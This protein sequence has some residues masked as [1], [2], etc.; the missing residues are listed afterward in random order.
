M[1]AMEWSDKGI[2]LSARPHG[3]T[4]SVAM[5]FTEFH[6]RHAGLVRGG[7]GQ[8]ARGLYQA[9]NVV[10]VVWRARLEE[11]LGNFRCELVHAAA[12]G[13]LHDALRLS[14]L[15]AACAVLQ[16]ALPER[17]PYATLYAR[18]VRLGE[19]IET[20]ENWGVSYARFELELLAEL[21]FGLDLSAC[22]VTGKAEDLL[23]VSPRS[24]RAVSAAA[25]AQWREKLLPLPEF[26][27]QPDGTPPE[28]AALS[29]ALQLTGW[30]LATHIF[31][32]STV[33]PARERFLQRLQKAV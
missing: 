31:A 1:R 30:F 11:H 25:G 17:H 15:S 29:D 18:F 14:A 6:G 13:L 8:R 16:A 12:A 19:E 2:V 3:E 20:G 24:G 21:G 27:W 28:K 4:A 26:L 22:A 32:G 10:T 23:Y 5:L 7:Q 33:P 9:G